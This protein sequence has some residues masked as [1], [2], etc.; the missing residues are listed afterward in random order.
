MKRNGLNERVIATAGRQWR[1][2]EVP[3]EGVPGAVSSCCLI[4]ESDDI[5]RRIWHYPENWRALDDAQL[6]RVCE[7]SAA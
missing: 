4:C 7:R 1:V 3:A 5:V 2:R 6:L